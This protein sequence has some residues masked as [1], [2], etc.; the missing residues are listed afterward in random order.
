MNYYEDKMYNAVVPPKILQHQ[1]ITKGLKG[2]SWTS[3][4]NSL[5]SQQD[6]THETRQSMNYDNKSQLLIDLIDF[7][8]HTNKQKHLEGWRWVGRADEI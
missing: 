4:I 3:C 7:Y 8:K 2:F 6:K 5:M 1:K